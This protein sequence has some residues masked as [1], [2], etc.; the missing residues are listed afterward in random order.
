[1][2][3]IGN[4]LALSMTEFKLSNILVVMTLYLLRGE[5]ARDHLEKPMD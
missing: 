3:H 2:E 1:M 5:Y 4:S